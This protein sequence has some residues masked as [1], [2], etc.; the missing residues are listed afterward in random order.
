MKLVD[1]FIVGAPKCGTT[2][3]AQ[4]LSQNPLIVLSEPK[5][6]HYFSV[7]LVTGGYMPKTD[8]EYIE[9]FFP[10]EKSDGQFWGD[11]SV[12][13]MYSEVA[14]KRIHQYN[15]KASIVVMIRNPARAAFS[16]HQQMIF[17]NQEDTLDFGMAWG[18]SE[19]RY[20]GKKYPSFMTLDPKL[21]AYKHAYSFYNQI[22][23]IKEYF[24]D[25]QILIMTQ[26]DLNKKGVSAINEVSD[27]IGAP[28]YNYQIVRTNETFYMKNSALTNLMRSQ[29]VVKIVGFMKRTLKIRSLG[30]GRPSKPFLDNYGELVRADLEQDIFKMKRD[31]NIDLLNGK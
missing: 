3:L 16:L 5:E 2:A 30:I 19:D 25:K 9:T 29:S 28:K 10:N 11:A 14:I 7:D 17:Q 21:I 15:P 23:R 12:W 22:S 18:K 26:E 1:F 20:L 24:P 31:Y 4:I 6:S 13:H 27:F 8:G